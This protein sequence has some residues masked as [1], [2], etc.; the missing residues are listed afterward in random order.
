M[1]DFLFELIGSFFA[2]ILACHKYWWIVLLVVV[3]ALIIVCCC[4]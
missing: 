4:I 1:I 3:I 2:E